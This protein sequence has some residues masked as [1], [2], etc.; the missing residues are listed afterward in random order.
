MGCGVLLLIP[1]ISEGRDVEVIAAV[2]A[3]YTGAGGVLLDT[4]SD[5]DH[6]RTVHTLAA[7]DPAA[8]PAILS[9]GLRAAKQS[10]DLTVQD[11]IH[12]CVGSLDVAPVVYLTDAERGLACAAALAAADD[13]GAQVPVFLYGLLAGG[14]TRAEVRRG[15]PQG[16][17]QRL[18]A[19]EIRPD[20]GPS[21]L[22]PTAGAVLVAARPPL[23]AFNVELAASATLEQAQTIAA[24]IRDGGTDGL[25]GVRAIGLAL[26]RA[27]GLG[28]VQV[29]TN[30]EDH[31]AVPLAAVVEAVS[32]YAE[33]TGAELVGL[34]PEAAFHGFP[35]ALP[36]RGRRTVEEALDGVSC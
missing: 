30:V 33:V 5:P 28:L 20:F 9:A 25:P 11:G 12:P 36:V 3:A 18:A 10:I 8:I 32:R 22:H 21:T 23:V 24:A 1:N 26:T 16:L 31:R 34:A 15:G 19:G 29:S 17:R 35:D 7:P 27:D 4:H 14:R 6:H 2:G 13:L